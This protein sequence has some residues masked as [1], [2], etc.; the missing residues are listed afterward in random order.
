MEPET[1]NEITLREPSRSASSIQRQKL[2]LPS[3]TR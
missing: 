1:L 2:P 3:A